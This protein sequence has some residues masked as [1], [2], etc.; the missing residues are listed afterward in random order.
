MPVINAASSSCSVQLIKGQAVI[1]GYFGSMEIPT[2]HP[3]RGSHTLIIC[4][5]TEEET[6]LSDKPLVWL[7]N[8]VSSVEAGSI[9]EL[10]SLNGK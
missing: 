10:Y 1:I 4:S 5:P 7:S 6:Q 8:V 3:L 2:G 9:L